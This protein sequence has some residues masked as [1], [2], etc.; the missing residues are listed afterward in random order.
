MWLA[1]LEPALE[2]GKLWEERGGVV[3]LNCA[4]D[5]GCCSCLG[6]MAGLLLEYYP[7]CTFCYNRCDIHCWGNWVSDCASR[8]LDMISPR[9]AEGVIEWDLK[10]VTDCIFWEVRA[11]LNNKQTLIDVAKE[12][13]S[14]ALVEQVS[15]TQVAQS[16]GKKNTLYAL[17]KVMYSVL[18]IGRGKEEWELESWEK[19]AAVTKRH[20]KQW[21]WPCGKGP[22]WVVREGEVVPGVEER[23]RKL[24]DLINMM[25]GLVT[26][27]NMAR[28]LTMGNCCI[29]I[30]LLR[31]ALPNGASEVFKRCSRKTNGEDLLHIG[32]GEFL[33]AGQLV[34]QG[35]LKCYITMIM[36]IAILTGPGEAATKATRKVQNGIRQTTN[37][38]VQDIFRHTFNT[39]TQKTSAVIKVLQSSLLHL[40]TRPTKEEISKVFA[41]WNIS[42]CSLWGQYLIQQ[43]NNRLGYVAEAAGVLEMAISNNLSSAAVI[44]GLRKLHAVD[45][46]HEQE[47]GHRSIT[48]RIAETLTACEDATAESR[49]VRRW[50][51]ALVALRDFGQR[52]AYE[53]LWGL[54]GF[55]FGCGCVTVG[56]LL[57]LNLLRF[58]IIY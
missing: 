28:W 33:K 12:T 1:A 24:Q 15:F 4:V 34:E 58:N 50:H 16:S 6:W 49:V 17:V 42:M 57:R 36:T 10:R 55:G 46:Q 47:I 3:V 48:C 18:G 35:G 13:A 30:M 43:G 19:R 52:D 9:N 31:W 23:Q 44:E 37:Q 20:S 26:E 51:D 5:W 45:I 14:E 53:V 41:A 56:S 25:I 21:Y 32:G 7:W 11:I 54:G 29:A 8:G 22:M 38:E 2:L 27:G 40:K 39:T